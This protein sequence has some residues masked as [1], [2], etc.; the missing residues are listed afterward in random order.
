MSSDLPSLQVSALGVKAN[1]E[2]AGWLIG[3]EYMEG[4]V[5]D[6]TKLRKNSHTGA[7]QRFSIQQL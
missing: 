5:N 4:K 3:Q 6:L 2:T 1:S 7:D